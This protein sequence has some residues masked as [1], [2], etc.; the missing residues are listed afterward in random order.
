MNLTTIAPANLWRIFSTT[1][2][3]QLRKASQAGLVRC[4]E[5]GTGYR[6]PP[7]SAQRTLVWTRMFTICRIFRRS[8]ANLSVRS[9]NAPHLTHFARK[10]LLTQVA[11]C[12]M[13]DA[14]V[15]HT[16]VVRMLRREANVYVSVALTDSLWTY[17]SPI[18]CPTFAS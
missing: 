9:C 11:M 5:I 7:H 17:T 18:G 2:P 14:V 16:K 10:G 6:F 12:L 15:H 1:L 8:L 3:S 4:I 13:D